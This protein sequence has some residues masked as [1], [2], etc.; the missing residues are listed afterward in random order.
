M[1]TLAKIEQGKIVE[2]PVS[3]DEFKSR[4]PTTI[5]PLPPKDENLVGVGY[6]RVF[7]SKRPEKTNP[8]TKVQLDVVPQFLNGVWIQKWIEVP[9]SDEEV[10]FL[11]NSI[12]DRRN[13]LLGFS[14]WTQLQDA[15]KETSKLWKSYR[16]ELRDIPQ[17]YKNPWDV[18]WPNKPDEVKE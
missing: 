3:W 7:E 16:K 10:R 12:R 18:V 17:N 2:Y 15:P 11:W 5:F 4:F 8:K 14:D 9:Y 1:Y 6:V 13:K